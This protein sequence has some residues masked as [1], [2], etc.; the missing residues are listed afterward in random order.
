M[1]LRLVHS[2]PVA[3][4]GWLGACENC[5]EEAS[6]GIHVVAADRWVVL[7]GWGCLQEYAAMT[8]ANEDGGRYRNLLDHGA[9]R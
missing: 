4:T 1:S 5:A 8:A 9:D 6:D 3:E 7:C 2:S